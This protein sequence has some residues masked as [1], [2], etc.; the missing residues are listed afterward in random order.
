MYL[1]EAVIDPLG[2]FW[3]CMG[4]GLL[5]SSAAR[6]ALHG[7]FIWLWLLLLV[8]SSP[9]IVNQ[10]LIRYVDSLSS[11]VCLNQESVPLVVLGGGLDPRA[12]SSGDFHLLSKASLERT[13]TGI[14][15]AQKESHSLVI[16]S[17]GSSND[18]AGISEA[19]L[20]RN[21]FETN[22]ISA[23]RLLQEGSSTDT[24]ENALL[25]YTL[26]TQ[27][28]LSPR[29][30]LLTSALHLPRAKAAFEKEGIDVCATIAADSPGNHLIPPY[31]VMPESQT[32]GKS[33]DW[34]HEI[35]GWWYYKM[36][37]WI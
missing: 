32:L 15:L 3:I 10:A 34:L 8:F 28:G 14:R 4:V 18:V 20:M 27:A 33:A 13:Y 6:S 19:E 23:A 31:A 5:V 16:L 29:I 35:F 30:R 36:K 12:A 25:T 21:L 24:H 22:G 37:E 17:G 11:G 2:F 26:M 9:V 7:L 1:L